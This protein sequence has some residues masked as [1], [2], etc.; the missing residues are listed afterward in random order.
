MK[1]KVKSW[2]SFFK[3]IVSGEK[4]HDMRDMRDRDYKVGDVLTLQEFDPFGGGYSGSEYDVEIT[5]ITSV[6]TP[7]AMSSVALSNTHCILS[8][9]GV[10]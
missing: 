6:N 1:Y 7:C 3:A 5:Y 9:K 4:L 8:I 10:E 2:P